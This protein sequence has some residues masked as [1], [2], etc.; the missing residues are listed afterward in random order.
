MTSY[1]KENE[2]DSITEM[3]E[4]QVGL[5][6]EEESSP[7]L[8]VESQ[9]KRGRGRP[10]KYAKEE[11]EQKYKELTKQ[12]IQE[13]KEHIKVQKKEYYNDNYDNLLKTNRQYQERSRYALRLLN[14]I[15][16]DH[17]SLIHLAPELQIKLRTLVEQKQILSI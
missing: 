4:A 16:N 10:A 9:P 3:K 7:V 6:I 14:D 15:Y 12:W 1:N 13:N 17:D 8:T 11:R 2:M 5:S